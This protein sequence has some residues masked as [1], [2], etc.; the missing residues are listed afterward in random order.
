MDAIYDQSAYQFHAA[1]PAGR[2]GDDVHRLL[3]HAQRDDRAAI[4]DPRAFRL[5]PLVSGHKKD[6]VLTNR[7]AR[8][9]DRSRST[10]GIAP[11]AIRFSP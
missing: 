5:A 10:V 9:R 4:A 8:I 2:S 7:L 3:P 11:Q 6:V 1:A